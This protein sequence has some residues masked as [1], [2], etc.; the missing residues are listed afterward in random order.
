MMSEHP[1]KQVRRRER[2]RQSLKLCIMPY[3][4][5]RPLYD[6]E[7]L[8][9]GLCLSCCLPI[10]VHFERNSEEP[11]LTE[12]RLQ[13]TLRERAAEDRRVEAAR[14][15]AEMPGWVYYV[16]V[17][18]R[19]KIGYAADVATRI[20]AYPPETKLLA[21]HPGTLTLER[22]MHRRFQ[23]SRAAGREW[24]YRHKDLLDHIAEV[25]RQFGEPGKRGLSHYAVGEAVAE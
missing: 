23:G 1:A 22:D 15:R 16:Q 19:I 17:G 7:G 10:A 24:Y 3:C 11:R 2:A 18:D 21:T 9:L 5:N 13:R 12:Q 20:R 6:R 25:V 4:N 8:N 14:S